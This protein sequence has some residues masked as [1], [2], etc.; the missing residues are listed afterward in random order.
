MSGRTNEF[1]KAFIEM[2]QSI[3]PSGPAA[4]NP[5]ASKALPASQKAKKTRV[6]QQYSDEGIQGII[7]HKPPKKD[8]MDYFQD[9]CNK[10]TAE[11]MA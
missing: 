4:Q 1:L 8:V 2:R 3:V 5:S 9:L 10:L 7:E 11:K 6:R